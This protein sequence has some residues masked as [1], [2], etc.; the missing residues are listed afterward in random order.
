MAEITETDRNDVDALLKN[1]FL[2]KDDALRESFVNIALFMSDVKNF[3][4]VF[5][6]VSEL[7]RKKYNAISARDTKSN[8]LTRAI[9]EAA[10][11]YGFAVQE[12]VVFSGFISPTD[13]TKDYI[14]KAVLWKDGVGSQHGEYSHS[15]Q[16]LTIGQ[17]GKIGTQVADVYRETAVRAGLPG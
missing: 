14:A 16:W 4:V 10:S 7:L 6:G 15:L 8:V 3:K 5:Q 9:F 12:N 17:S 1:V 11:D 13:I 2:V